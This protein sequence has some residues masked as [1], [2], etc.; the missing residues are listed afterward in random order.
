MKEICRKCYVS[1]FL[2]AVLEALVVD[3]LVISE[4]SELRIVK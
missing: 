4:S 1:T 3:S 2:S